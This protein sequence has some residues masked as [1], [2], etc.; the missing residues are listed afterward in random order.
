MFSTKKRRSA[1]GQDDAFDLTIDGTIL[2]K[3]GVSTA[4]NK[5]LEKGKNDMLH[6]QGQQYAGSATYDT[7]D[8]RHSGIK[9]T[10]VRSIFEPLNFFAL[11]LGALFAHFVLGPLIFG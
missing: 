2:S 9:T 5:S 11:V 6:K 10:V 7:V 8:N 3:V 1:G 4:Y